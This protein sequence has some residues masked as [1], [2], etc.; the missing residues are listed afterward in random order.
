M[1]G[2]RWAYYTFGFGA[3]I[4]FGYHDIHTETALWLSVW[5]LIFVG[6]LIASRDHFI[7]S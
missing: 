5:L 3:G 6:S 7:D 2:I 4:G 1:V